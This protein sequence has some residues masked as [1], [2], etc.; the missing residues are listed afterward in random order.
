MPK[1]Y[2][3]IRYHHPLSNIII[4]PLSSLTDETSKTRKTRQTRLICG[5]LTP[6][7]ECP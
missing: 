3:R 5:R 7:T 1:L 2:K 6:L 4:T